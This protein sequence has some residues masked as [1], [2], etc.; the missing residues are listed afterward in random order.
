MADW[1][2]GMKVHNHVKITHPQA[3]K[4]IRGKQGRK[5]RTLMDPPPLPPETKGSFCTFTL[6]FWHM[7]MNSSAGL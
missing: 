7:K 1:D 3:E 2:V 4:K 6:A 5:E